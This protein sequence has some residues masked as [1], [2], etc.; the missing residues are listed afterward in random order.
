MLRSLT[1]WGRST[2]GYEGTGGRGGGVFL[3]GGVGAVI[4]V[5]RTVTFAEDL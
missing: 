1:G 3:L 4:W 5:A 2:R